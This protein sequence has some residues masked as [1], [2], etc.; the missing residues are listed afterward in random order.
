MQARAFSNASLYSYVFSNALEA[1]MPQIRHYEEYLF[2]SV[3]AVGVLVWLIRRAK[4]G[5]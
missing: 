5:S 4:R 2:I 1:L 3:L